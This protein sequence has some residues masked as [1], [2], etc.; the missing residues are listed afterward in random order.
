MRCRPL[1]AA[2]KADEF[3]FYLEDTSA[4][5]VIKGPDAGEAIAEAAPPHQVMNLIATV[6]MTG[7]SSWRKSSTTAREWTQKA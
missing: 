1:D 2:Y 4:K 3:A 7:K 5:V 6:G